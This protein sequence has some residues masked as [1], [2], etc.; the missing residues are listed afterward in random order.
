MQHNRTVTRTIFA[1]IGSVQ[2]LRQNEIQLQRST[3]PRPANCILQ[4]KLQLRSVKSTLAGQI[5][6]SEARLLQRIPQT[7]FCTVPDLVRSG[8]LLRPRRFY[9]VIALD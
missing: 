6:I 9:R 1:N 5:L 4:M 3:L 7:F 8:A 2:T